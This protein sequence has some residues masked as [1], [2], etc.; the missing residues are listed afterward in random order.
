MPHSCAVGIALIKGP[1]TPLDKKIHKVIA[2]IVVVIIIGVVGLML[3]EGW[4]F[5]DALYMTIITISTVGY[6][7]VHDL[8]PAGRVFILAFIVIGV[9][10][11]FYVITVIAEYIVAG[12]LKGALGRKKM[13]K[14][15]DKLDRHYIICGFGRVGQQVA[16]EFIRERVK[17][18]V[19]D[20]NPAAIAACNHHG[21]L[22]VEGSASD[23]NILRLAGVTRARGLVA[24]ADSDSENVYVTLSAKNLCP[25][26]YV[27]ARASRESAEQKLIMAHADRVTSPYSIGGRRLASMII[28]PNVVD[29]LDVVM[30]SED[31]KMFMEEISVKKGSTLDGLTIGEAKARCVSGANILAIKKFGVR[32]VIPSPEAGERIGEGDMLITLGTREQLSEFEKLA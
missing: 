11:F 15:I 9:S 12:H 21:F 7:E 22:Y 31:Y 24:A 27:V 5:F 4:S 23:D 10:S 16:Q 30:H 26:I 17:F 28:R 29:F 14:Q 3:I 20:I 25:G 32:H 19:I 6:H 1:V 18:V 13:Q 8:T 2:L